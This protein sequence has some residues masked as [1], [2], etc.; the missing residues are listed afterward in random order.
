M[1]ERTGMDYEFSN[2]MLADVDLILNIVHGGVS[3][4]PKS[5]G[6]Q[7][8]KDHIFPQKIL[9]QKNIPEE[10]INN[11]GNLRLI[12]KTRNII[13]S[14]N[15]PAQD[16]EF[17]GREN[18]EMSALF[19]KALNNLIRENYEAFVLKRNELIFNKVKNFLGIEHS[20]E[21][22]T[23]PPPS[24]KEEPDG[25]NKLIDQY[26]SS[27]LRIT[28]DILIPF[29]VAVLGKNNGKAIAGTVREE[30]YKTFKSEFIQEEWQRI[31]GGVPR[32]QKYIDYAKFRA[33]HDG[34][35]KSPDEA[36]RGNWELTP[37]GFEYYRQMVEKLRNKDK[38]D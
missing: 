20:V 33:R 2:T 10:L 1:A 36:G 5:K 34:Y 32:W 18:K 15:M 13:K 21:P 8:E 35:I 16:T 3:E 12:N 24:V 6:W 31:T 22:R 17:F 26:K 38:T 9:T 14:Y 4:I 7:I 25:L 27:K 19:L 28:E 30:I 23:P 11:T 37:K 29:I